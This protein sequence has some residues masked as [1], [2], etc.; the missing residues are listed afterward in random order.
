MQN[1][2]KLLDEVIKIVPKF[3]VGIRSVFFKVEELTNRQ[4]VI[5]MF[6]YENPH[7]KIS[8]IAK[9]FRV[10][11]PTITG[12]VDRLCKK[13]YLRRERDIEDRRVV[14]VDLNKK[15][16]SFLRRFFKVTKNKW[17]RIL[18]SLT[19]EERFSYISILKKITKNLS[20][21]R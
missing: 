20:R 3:I 13:K 11:D 8:D 9:T 1:I 2:E 14:Y 10:S 19:E 21:E 16:R 5:L 18:G 17:K 7:C 12:I 15:G 6:I 4:I